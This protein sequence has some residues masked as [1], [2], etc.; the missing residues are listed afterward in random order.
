MLPVKKITL[1]FIYMYLY[2]PV[3]CS[4]TTNSKKIACQWAIGT[5]PIYI[6][7]MTS[8]I[9]DDKSK[10]INCWYI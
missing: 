4:N 10:S 7:K 5:Q 8:W 2:S 6:R 3:L 1:N 9:F